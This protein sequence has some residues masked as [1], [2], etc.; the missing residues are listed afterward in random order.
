N[1]KYLEAQPTFLWK[2]FKS[3]EYS[4]DS[5]KR[6]MQIKITQSKDAQHEEDILK[7]D[8]SP[9]RESFQ[10]GDKAAAVK[11]YK[12]SETLSSGNYFMSLSYQEKSNFGD[13]VISR[14]SN[15]KVPFTVQAK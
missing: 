5:E 9:T 14:A 6:S 3:P 11:D 1:Q 8:L 4:S 12:G 15:T 7:V 13:L 2:Q 10:V